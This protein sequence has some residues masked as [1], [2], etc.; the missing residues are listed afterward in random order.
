M[1]LHQMRT[2]C[3]LWLFTLF[4]SAELVSDWWNRPNRVFSGATPESIWATDPSKI[5]Q[6]LVNATDSEG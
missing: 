1:N 2:E 3:N 4:G 5:Y 6:Y